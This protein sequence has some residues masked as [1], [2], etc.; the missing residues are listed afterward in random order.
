QSV[1]S[2]KS[3]I[4]GAI[5]D[6][7]GTAMPDY[8]FAQFAQS[9]RDLAQ[10]QYDKGYGKGDADGYAR[11]DSDGYTRGDADGYNRG[12]TEGYGEGQGDGYQTG[13]L[14]GIDFADKRVNEESE[15][16]KKGKESAGT[17]TWSTSIHLTKD[18][19]NKEPENFT[20]SAGG[21]SN[22]INWLYRKEFP[23][24]KILAIHV[25]ERYFSPYGSSN[26]EV[27]AVDVGGRYQSMSQG[28]SRLSLSSD[29]FSWGEV[30]FNLSS[31][32]LFTDIEVTVL[33]K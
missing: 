33:Y 2:G 28:G 5:T 17:K 23:G 19:P 22:Y 29:G 4:A 8:N 24:H 9:I 32:N 15:S 27:L 13:Y 21:S 20:Q 6:K 14:E 3:L 16:Y 25:I 1:S 12:K 26:F 30:S 18:G 7:E 11:G 31:T 10:K